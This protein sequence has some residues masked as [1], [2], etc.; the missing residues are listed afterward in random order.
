M[1]ETPLQVSEVF[2]ADQFELAMLGINLLK[3]I[4]GFVIAY[5][6]YRGYR[7][8]ES[9]PMLYISTGFILLLAVPFVSFAVAISL[10]AA[11]DLPPVAEQGVVVVSELSQLIG[12]LVI[13]YALRM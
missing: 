13:V 9:R 4:L 5:I 10:V 6:A 2:R 8:N 12:L 7:R 11:V 1:L 3:G